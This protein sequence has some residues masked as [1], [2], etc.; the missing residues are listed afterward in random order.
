ML[1]IIIENWE[2]IG[3]LLFTVLG[4][5]FPIVKLKISQVQFSA[6]WDAIL[7]IIEGLEKSNEEVNADVNKKKLQVKAGYNKN[8][9]RVIGKL[10]TESIDVIVDVIKAPHLPFVAKEAFKLFKGF[11]KLF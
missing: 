8:I 11:K 10:P 6:L 9:K 3:L 2:V 7:S 4:I 5:I 1:N